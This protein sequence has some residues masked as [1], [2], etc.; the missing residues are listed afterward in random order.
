HVQVDYKFYSV[1]YEYVR[2]N[3]D[4]RMTADLIELYFKEVRIASHPCKKKADDRYST[5]PDHMPDN[6]RLY[7]DH[8]P[9]NNRKWARDIGQDM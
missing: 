7:L 5:N 6:H 3:V 1:P 4:V 9:E 8:N 2:E